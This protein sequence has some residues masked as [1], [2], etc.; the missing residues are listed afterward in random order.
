MKRIGEEVA[1]RRGELVAQC[2][3]RTDERLRRIG[4]RRAVARDPDHD[5]RA[6][7]PLDDKR[8]N[9][10]AAVAAHIDDQPLLFDLREVLLGELVQAP[11]PHIGDVNVADLAIRLLAHFID[12]LLHPGAVI[13]RR[14]VGHRA[15]R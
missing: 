12:V 3:H 4:L 8:R 14:L 2:D 11:L 6:P 10:A 5:E 7:Q 13:K 15:Q 9:K 1:V